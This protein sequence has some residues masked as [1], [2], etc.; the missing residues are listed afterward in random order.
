MKGVLLLL[1]NLCQTLEAGRHGKLAPYTYVLLQKHCCRSLVGG[2]G[3]NCQL[4][5]QQP[6]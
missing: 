4:S 6:P 1:G 3:I 2:L 5:N